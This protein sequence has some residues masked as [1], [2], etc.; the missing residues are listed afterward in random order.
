MN[1][2]SFIKRA[3]GFLGLAFV[4][5]KALIPSEVAASAVKAGQNPVFKGYYYQR[6]IYGWHRTRFDNKNFGAVT[7]SSRRA[8]K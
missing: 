3:A 6:R 1:R 2:R 8:N 4:A 5:P 7:M